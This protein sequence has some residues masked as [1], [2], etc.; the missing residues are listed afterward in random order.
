MDIVVPGNAVPGSQLGWM[1]GSP[2]QN[3]AIMLAEDGM[4]VSMVAEAARD[5]V[6]NLLCRTLEQ[7]GV[8]IRSIDRPGDGTPTPSSIYF[9]AQA[10]AAPVI[11]TPQPSER[12]DAVWPDIDPGDIVIFGSAVVLQPR[13]HQFMADFLDHIAD[14]NAISIYAPLLT[15]G[16]VTRITRATPAI[17]EYLEHAH[18]TVMRR[19]DTTMLFSCSD[20]GK[21]YNN[22]IRFY[23][24][25]MVYCDSE[26]NRVEIYQNDRNASAAA[27]ENPDTLM[28]LAG[29]LAA[30]A[31][32]ID[33]AGFSISSNE[34]APLDVPQLQ[35]IASLTA[36]GADSSA[37]NAVVNHEL[38]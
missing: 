2:L 1:P 6:G 10:S 16:E 18:I 24:R 30:L 31:K 21:C 11:Y 37:K 34:P 33:S 22:H 13:M 23:C 25:T 32:A 8:D 27:K 15:P 17:L 9:P 36:S 28:W 12:F 35:S 29:A 14:R 19:T 5:S 7:A 3:A 38:Q 4:K 26:P 20:P